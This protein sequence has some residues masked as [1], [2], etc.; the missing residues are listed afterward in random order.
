MTNNLH[1]VLGG[2]GAIGQAVIKA[3]QEKNLNIRV[4]ERSKAVA[5]VETIFADLLDQKQTAEALKGASHVY[6]C[7]GLPYESKVWEKDWSRLMKSVIEACALVNAK[8]IFFDNVYMYGPSPLAVPFAENHE[9][10]PV[11]IKGKVRKE[12]ANLMIEAM[13]SGKIKGVIGRSATF[14]GPKAINSV[15]YISFLQN[16]LARK[17][18]QVII[19]EGVKQTFAYTLDN[20]RALVTLALDESV[21]GEVYHLPVGEAVT[22]E[23]ILANFN[24]ELNTSFKVS[25]VNGFL[26]SFLSLFIKS[27]RESKEMLY[28]YENP[29]IMSWEKFKKKYPEFKVTSYEEGFK[30]M[31]KSFKN[32]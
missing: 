27:L 14:Y 15:L 22:V 2:S 6:L 31:I 21:S 19:G 26:L 29:H 23:Q 3:L 5:G 12:I 25:Y 18:P 13:N 32:Q 4:V 11:S 8:L 1:V 16:M 30:E 10:K 7:V 28:L 24:K 9:Q 20:G 17:N